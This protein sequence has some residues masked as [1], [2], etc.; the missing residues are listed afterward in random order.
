[1]NFVSKDST[2]FLLDGFALVAFGSMIAVLES[3]R[4]RLNRLVKEPDSGYCQC[5]NCEC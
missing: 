4:S 5:D 2:Q 3:L 1:M